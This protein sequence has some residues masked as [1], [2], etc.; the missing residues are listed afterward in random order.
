MISSLSSASARILRRSATTKDYPTKNL[1]SSTIL[2]PENL[3]ARRPSSSSSSTSSSY[4]VVVHAAAYSDA[5]KFSSHGDALRKSYD[6]DLSIRR[7]PGEKTLGIGKTEVHRYKA[8]A[9]GAPAYG[10]SYDDGKEERTYLGGRGMASAGL[11]FSE[12]YDDVDSYYGTEGEFQ[13]KDDEDSEEEEMKLGDVTRTDSLS[14]GIVD[15]FAVIAF[16]TLKEEEPIPI[17]ASKDEKQQKKKGLEFAP[18]QQYKVSPNDIVVSHKLRPVDKWSVGSVHVST[19]ST[20]LI[21]CL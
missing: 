13:D 7:R 4:A 16:A 11:N 10:Y 18:T 21:I 12:D 19:V 14:V 15:S 9:S 3:G 17:D 5:V 2:S 20:H 8:F 6:V 1:Q